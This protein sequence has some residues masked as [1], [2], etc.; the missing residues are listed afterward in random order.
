MNKQ[1]TKPSLQTWMI[2]GVSSGLGRALAEALLAS[3]RRVVGT[4]RNQAARQ[5]FVALA[6][7]L[8]HAVL[9]DVSDE[10]AIAG[11]VAQVEAD[12]GA[13]DVLVN[14][15]GYGLEGAVEESSMAEIRRQF[16]VNVFGLIGVTQAVLPYMRARRAGHIV[17]ISSMGGLMAFAG[18]AVYNSS[19][20]A[21][22]GLSEGLAKEVA[23]LGIRVTVVE[24]GGFRTNWAGA[25]M[26]HVAQ[27]IADYEL[28]AGAMRAG[29]EQRNGRQIGDPDKAAL[30]IIAA[31]S[32][33]EPPMHL[34]LGSDAFLHVGK[35]LGDLQT[36]MAKWAGLSLSTGFDPA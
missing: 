7:G 3:G 19:K 8:A 14:N 27:Q 35:K 28:S 6:P 5:E 20:F 29:L 24:P 2:T 23:H 17:N 12:I 21:V 33:D 16:E 15:A 26:T 11:V 36:E 9:L 18:L 25:S 1:T 31:I 22:V 30:A 34:L 32:A 4:V 10:Q 13:I